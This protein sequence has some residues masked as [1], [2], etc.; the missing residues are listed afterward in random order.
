MADCVLIWSKPAGHWDLVCSQPGG[1]HAHAL[2]WTPRPPHD[3]GDSWGPWVYH[4]A[5]RELGYRDGERQRETYWVD[6]DRCRSGGEVLDWI[7]QLEEKAW[8]TETDLGHFVRALNDVVGLRARR[9]AKA[10]TG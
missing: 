1:F 7:A 9:W 10:Q 8:L 4:A 5:T 3:D 6:L 2:T